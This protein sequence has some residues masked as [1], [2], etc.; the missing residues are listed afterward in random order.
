M[1]VFS[2]TGEYV[3]QALSSPLC[4]RKDSGA[5]WGMGLLATYTSVGCCTDPSQLCSERAEGQGNFGLLQV[6]LLEPI[7]NYD[8]VANYTYIVFDCLSCSVLLQ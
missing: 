6:S 7:M 1:S 3:L 2:T 8:I 4:D 5:W